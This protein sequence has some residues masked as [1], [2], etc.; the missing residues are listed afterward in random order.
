M[1]LDK[2]EIIEKIHYGIDQ[3]IQNNKD[4]LA[5]LSVGSFAQG[6][7]DKFSDIDLYIFTNDVKKYIVKED[8]SWFNPIGEIL[9]RMIF[10]DP[11]SKVD[12]NMIVLDNGIT[13][14]LTIVKANRLTIFKIYFLF[15]KL[16]LSFAIPN[17]IKLPLEDIMQK[18]YSVIKR[19]YKVNSD[20]IGLKKVL[21]EIRDSSKVIDENEVNKNLFEK[22]YHYFWHCCYIL[23]VNLIRRDFYYSILK[24]DREIKTELIRMIEW[25]TLLNDNLKDVYYFGKKIEKWGGVELVNELYKTL[26]ENNIVQM[27]ISLLH[28]IKLY[29]KYSY[30]VAEKHNYP[31]NKDFEKF[32]IHFIKNIA[33]PKS[34]N[35]L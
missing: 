29:K 24:Y 18:F 33:I 35:E 2:T 5:L 25:D 19:G 17:F 31:L 13:Y 12:K 30:K 22:S 26:L 27:Q 34:K 20:N 1:K 16:R 9:S 6:T 21:S 15:K 3:L 28:T 23:S 11:I 10:N 14:D 32:I 8:N 4:I 7:L